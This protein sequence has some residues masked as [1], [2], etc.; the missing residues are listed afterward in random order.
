MK[1]TQVS[2]Q[3]KEKLDSL[4]SAN[5]V[6]ENKGSAN[7]SKASAASAPWSDMTRQSY[8]A[9]ELLWSPFSENTIVFSKIAKSFLE[10]QRH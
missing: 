5:Q 8:R 6:R 7:Q 9:V 3:I 4:F 2:M 1:T 10:F